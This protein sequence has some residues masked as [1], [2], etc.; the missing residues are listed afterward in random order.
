MFAALPAAPNV[1]S[2]INR[3]HHSATFTFKATATTTGFQCA[4]IKQPKKKHKKRAKPHFTGC[5]PPKTYKHLKNGTY[6]FEVRPL[7]AAGTGLSTS[8]NFKI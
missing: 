7:S 8:K 1:T 2:K 5:S 3:K 4:L 6:T